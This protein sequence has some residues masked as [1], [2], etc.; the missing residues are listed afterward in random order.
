MSG[1]FR[2]VI[3]KEERVAGAVGRRK[4]AIVVHACLRIRLNSSATLNDFDVVIAADNKSKL[5]GTKCS[6]W[7]TR[8]IQ[9]VRSKIASSQMAPS[10]CH[11][12]N[13]D[14]GPRPWRNHWRNPWCRKHHDPLQT[15]ELAEGSSTQYSTGND[16][17]SYTHCISLHGFKAIIIQSHKIR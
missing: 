1:I 5:P 10:K 4:L 12:T 11:E 16:R 7:P 2:L 17:T 14:C 8:S 15:P 9:G 3:T 6:K 13:E